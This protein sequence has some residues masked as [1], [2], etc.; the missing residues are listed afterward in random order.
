MIFL[1]LT[2]CFN[3]MLT[4]SN[5]LSCADHLSWSVE[6]SGLFL[7]WSMEGIRI[8]LMI[9]SRRDQDHNC[10]DQRKGS[11]SLLLWSVEG[12]RIFLVVISRRSGSFCDHGYH[13]ISFW[14]LT[15]WKALAL[16]HGGFLGTFFSSSVLT[17]MGSFWR[18]CH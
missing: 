8:I 6:G 9:I 1:K 2:L 14:D 17:L 3:S 4:T 12:I 11:G 7:T 5:H 13:R 15:S 10:H 16:R 18:I